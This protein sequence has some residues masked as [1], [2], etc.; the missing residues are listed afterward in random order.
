MVR[1]NQAGRR[2]LGFVV[3]MA[4]TIGLFAL[5]SPSG[6]DVTAVR[7][8]AYGYQTNVSLFGG[9]SAIRGFGQTTCTSPN[10]PAGCAPA[11]A[12]SPSVNL[13][14]TGG[15]VSQTD[16][17]GATAQ[18]GPAV[19]FGGRWPDAA[20]SAPPSGPISVDCTGTTGPGGSVTCNSAVTLYNP[21]NALAPG[22]I[23]PGPV[24]AD[25]ARSTCSAVETDPSTGAK[26]V[27]GSATFV[28]GVLETR[29]DPQTQLP[30]ETEPIP[31]NPP[32][33][34]TRSGTIDHV[35]DSYS[36]VF[37][38]Q[39]INPDGSLTVNAVHMRLLGPTA[40]GDLII[41]SV[42]CG[43]TTVGV[44]TTQTPTTQTPTTQTPTTVVTTTTT[45]TPPIGGFPDLI[46]QIVCPLLRTLAA[47]PFIGPF[48]Q[49]LLTA[50]GCTA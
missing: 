41:G 44:P 40:V 15:N 19:I 18:Y 17:N 22:G 10:V 9:P 8:S 23:G 45:T 14:S 38:E 33:N 37:N 48:I 50:F 7:G 13:P 24:V 21:P 1:R 29:Y 39:I 30:V 25:E 4:M 26:S 32:P 5:S 31:A 28:N 49:P 11:T 36:V 2:R 16:P 35:G 12:E 46:R 3:V 6:A 20:P 27:T 43:I 42:T 34:Y 47:S